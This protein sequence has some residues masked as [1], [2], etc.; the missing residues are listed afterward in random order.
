M[1]A[2][3]LEDLTRGQ[4][5]AKQNHLEIGM[6]D[7]M[8]YMNHMNTHLPQFCDWVYSGCFMRSCDLCLFLNAVG[9]PSLGNPK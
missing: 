3:D 5:S 6:V 7:N 4:H 9:I 1:V 2:Y 8:Q